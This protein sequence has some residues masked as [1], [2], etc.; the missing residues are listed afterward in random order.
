MPTF[1]E[2]AW[3][4]TGGLYRRILD[5]PFN[6]ELAAGALS[7]ERFR[8]YMIQDALYLAQYARAL[9]VASAKAPDMEAIQF[10]A[11]SAETAIVVERALHGGF[12][13][14]FGV[15][16]EEAAKVEPSPTCASYTNFLLATA[17]QGNYA[18]LTAAVLPCFWIYWEVGKYIAEIAA[19]E[20]PYQPWIDTYAGTEFGDAVETAIVI[21]DRAAAAAS[22]EEREGMMRAYKRSAQYEWMFW[23]SAYELES[24]PVSVD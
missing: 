5:L 6:R 24:W 11:K 20:N 2:Q 1:S 9:S 4:E 23:D 15:D 8:F 18:E 21:T 12:F 3:T 19:P 14:T 10:F 22:D 16:P 7:Q 13:E 17:L